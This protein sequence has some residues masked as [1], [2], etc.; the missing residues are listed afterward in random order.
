MLYPTVVEQAAT[1]L[2]H[3]VRNHPFVDGNKRTGWRACETFL[4]AKSLTLR[5]ETLE[6]VEFVESV[7][8]GHLSHGEIVN[9]VGNH[10]RER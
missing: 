4:A 2:E 8:A 9:W 3:V 1:L 5:V 7:A 10:I 6:A